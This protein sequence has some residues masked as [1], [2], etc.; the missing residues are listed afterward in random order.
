MIALRWV[1]PMAVVL[2]LSSVWGFLLAPLP[3]VRL[4]SAHANPSP[5][6]RASLP[7]MQDE[8]W[9]PFN[10]ATPDESWSPLH[11]AAWFGNDDSARKLLAE[12]HP[13]D[14]QITSGHTPLHITA[15]TGNVEVAKCLLNS[16]SDINACTTR[17]HTPLH[18][19]IEH[20]QLEMT[21][22]LLNRGAANNSRDN[23]GRQPLHLA[24][25]H[26]AQ[27]G[28]V[29]A[30]LDHDAPVNGACA[31]GLTP[32]D[33]AVYEQAPD[34][35]IQALLDKGARIGKHLWNNQTSL[36]SASFLGRETTVDMLLA[37]GA[38]VDANLYLQAADGLGE[39]AGCFVAVSCC[40]L[41]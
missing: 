11:V 15:E 22:L 28:L 41:S 20:K 25:H 36:H 38:S 23:L 30:L 37:H 21:K 5:R 12:G 9:S 17:Q 33:V 18:L 13:V 4:C 35:C 24:A 7:R 31:H 34:A 2:Q 27:P 6:V 3:T 19:A 14:P 40:L 8:S 29:Y 39:R 26:A 1:V 32:L 16:S 10:F